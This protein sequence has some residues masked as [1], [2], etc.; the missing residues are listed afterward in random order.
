MNLMSLRKRSLAAVEP[1]VS[2]WRWRI[3]E[4]DDGLKRLVGY[5]FL[6]Q[7]CVSSALISFN[8]KAMRAQSSDGLT[9]QLVGKPGGFWEVVDVWDSRFDF[10]G[11][12]GM[13]K[14]V[15]EEM[16][17]KLAGHDDA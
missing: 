2:L 10:N 3:F 17:T 4:N 13:T 14:D 8:Q 7:G 16:L 5:D 1:D 11:G 6:D 9:Y 12:G 15:T